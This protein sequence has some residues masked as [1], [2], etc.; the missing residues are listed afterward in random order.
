MR[1]RFLAGVFVL[2]MPL[3]SG[4]ESFPVSGED[5][6]P[7]TQDNGEQAMSPFSPGP[8]WTD[9]VQTLSRMLFMAKGV[10]AELSR[11]AGDASV[12][13]DVRLAAQEAL[14]T[15][16]P[17]T[18]GVPEMASFLAGWTL[19]NEPPLDLAWIAG[20]DRILEYGASA[21]AVL[22]SDAAD[23]NAP[24]WYR[25]MAGQLSGVSTSP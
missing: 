12:P 13:R 4:A 18:N 22:A 11:I 19:T 15:L 16:R 8:D 17:G 7:R 24:A 20:M 1:L 10:S 21:K 3:A 9:R 14:E 25:S 23:S 2:A 6:V 5:I